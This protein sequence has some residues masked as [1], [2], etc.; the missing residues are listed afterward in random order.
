VQIKEIKQKIINSLRQMAGDLPSDFI[1]NLE[2]PLQE[3]RGELTFSCFRLAK[4]F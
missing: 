2:V 1:F 4:H 3:E